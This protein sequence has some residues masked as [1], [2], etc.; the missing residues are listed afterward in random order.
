V[1]T[2]LTIAAA[3]SYDTVVQDLLGLVLI[4]THTRS[5]CYVTD[6]LPPFIMQFPKHVVTF[7]KCLDFD[8]TPHQLMSAHGDSI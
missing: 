6:S 8:R 1:H 7:F 2:A 3:H 4:R 5:R